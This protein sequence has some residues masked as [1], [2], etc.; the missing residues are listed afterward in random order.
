MKY[1]KLIS[2]VSILFLKHSQLFT[3]VTYSPDQIIQLSQNQGIIIFAPPTNPKNLPSGWKIT[4]ALRGYYLNNNSTAILANLTQKTYIPYISIDLV[5]SVGDSSTKQ[6][7][8]TMWNPNYDATKD[9]FNKK[10]GTPLNLITIYG[11]P[12]PSTDSIFVPSTKNLGILPINSNPAYFITG[13]ENNMVLQGFYLPSQ[14]SAITSSL[15]SETTKDP[16]IILVN[17]QN[18]Y[19]KVYRSISSLTDVSTSKKSTPIIA[20]LQ[21]PNTGLPDVQ[22]FGQPY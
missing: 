2:F 13:K 17:E 19:I 11:N 3:S 8:G 18:K 12:M 21:A 7:I 6:L 10:S 4:D 5:T 9:Q 1:I 14:A 20:T 22:F 16:L 15:T